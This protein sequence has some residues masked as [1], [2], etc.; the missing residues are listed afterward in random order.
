MSNI[1]SGC[2]PLFESNLCHVFRHWEN[3]WRKNW[4]DSPDRLLVRYGIGDGLNDWIRNIHVA[5]KCPGILGFSRIVID[6]VDL[7][8]SYL[9]TWAIIGSKS[10]PLPLFS[11]KFW[12]M[13]QKCTMCIRTGPFISQIRRRIWL[14][15]RLCDY[16][17]SKKNDVPNKE[18]HRTLPSLLLLLS[19]KSTVK[20]TFMRDW[21]ICLLFFTVGHVYW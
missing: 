10:Y 19:V 12:T 13:R 17:S 20:F 14:G 3:E 21:V 4:N 2:L 16:K 5:R 11:F 6:Y 9:I 18:F 8:R 7:L 1:W 15:L